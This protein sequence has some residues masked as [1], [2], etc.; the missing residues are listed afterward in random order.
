MAYF[1]RALTCGA[2]KVSTAKC[3]DLLAFRT[4]TSV[5]KSHLCWEVIS[6]AKYQR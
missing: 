5:V 2:S 3:L 6:S 4:D 1:V